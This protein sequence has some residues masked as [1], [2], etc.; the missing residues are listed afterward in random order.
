ML[1]EAEYFQRK[2]PC[3]E[4]CSSNKSVQTFQSGK[5]FL[6]AAVLSVSFG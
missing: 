2:E 6:E 3:Q 4:T 1:F 5:L